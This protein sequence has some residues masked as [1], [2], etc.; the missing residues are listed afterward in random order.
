MIQLT[1][2]EALFIEEVLQEVIS[3]AENEELLESTDELKQALEIIR[4]CNV[5][6]EL[7]MLE[8]VVDE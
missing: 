1:N 7:K 3:L 4:S 6:S 8:D 2:T 5:Y